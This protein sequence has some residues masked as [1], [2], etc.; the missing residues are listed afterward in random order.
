MATARSAARRG[1]GELVVVHGGSHAWMLKDPESLPAIIHRLMQGRLGTAVLKAILD[2]GIDPND[3]TDDEIESAF[4]RPDALVLRLTPVGDGPR[5]RGPPPPPPL[6]LHHHDGL[7]ATS[8]ANVGATL[9][10]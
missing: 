2:A 9:A 4:Y 10:P 6:P 1:R 5:R 7:T 8:T 3:A